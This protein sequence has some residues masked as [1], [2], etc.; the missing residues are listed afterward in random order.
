MYRDLNRRPPYLARA[1]HMQ[2][3]PDVR[4]SYGDVMRPSTCTSVPSSVS[5]PQKLTNL[6]DPTYLKFLLVCNV[7]LAPFGIGDSKST[8]Q[9]LMATCLTGLVHVRQLVLPASSSD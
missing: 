5:L 9:H 4:F 3:S 6:E 7:H 1:L 8:Y 2:Y